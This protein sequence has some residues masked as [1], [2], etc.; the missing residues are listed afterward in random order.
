MKNKSNAKFPWQR[1]LPIVSCGLILALPAKQAISAQ[2]QT[3]SCTAPA[4]W[5]SG[6]P[7]IPEEVPNN[8]NDFC[9]FYQFTWQS[10]ISLM[11]PYKSASTDSE[12]NAENRN[13]SNTSDYPLY[14]LGANGAPANSCDNTITGVTLKN[15]LDKSGSFIHG[16]AGGGDVIFDQAGNIVYYDMR[17]SR[18]MCDDADKIK[19][20]TNFPGGT[21]ELKTAWKVLTKTDN[22]ADYLVWNNPQGAPANT[23][24]GLIGFHFAIATPDHPEFI[25]ATFEHNKNAPDCNKP[26]TNTGW[27]FI[28]ESCSAALANSDNTSMSKCLNQA[29]PNG[30]LTGVPTEI[31]RVYPHGTA[32]DDWKAEE[33][34]SDIVS[35]NSSVHKQLTG[36]MSIFKNY[37]NV[38]AIWVSDITKDS[39]VNGDVSNQRGSLRLAN[40]VAET[41]FQW[42]DTN[43]K[44]NDGFASNCFG[45]HGYAGTDTVKNK[46]TT[47]GL[48]SH[49]FDDIVVGM[50]QCVD[51]QAGPIY[52]QQDAVKKCKDGTSDAKGVCPNLGLTWNGQWS[53]TE[54]GVMSVC[55]CCK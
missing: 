39:S 7:G 21:T 27:S 51:V 44:T 36:D 41:T 53:T 26:A 10:F 31:C 40:T 16:E 48:L 50:G 12:N 22:Q 37:F 9:D 29:A 20:A 55:G 6:D 42:V 2:T 15:A 17:F 35:M 1:Y 28:S 23:T 32:A 43:P 38:G 4:S 34:V 24:L 18:N 52:S 11:S 25:W 30:T 19:N 3:T 14:E 8:G 13:F 49:I 46:N 33:N 45:C 5:F 54:E 47:S